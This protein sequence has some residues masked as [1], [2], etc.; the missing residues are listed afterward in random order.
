MS[1]DM[2]CPCK[3]GGSSAVAFEGITSSLLCLRESGCSAVMVNSM[4]A[5]ADVCRDQSWE[6]LSFQTQS[7]PFVFS[8]RY[9]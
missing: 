1:G 7:Q 3:S 2:V 6:N 4:A 9:W 8:R 5:E